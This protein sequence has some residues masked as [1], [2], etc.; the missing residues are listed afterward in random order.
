MKI[1]TISRFVF[2]I[3]VVGPTSLFAGSISGV[4]VSIDRIQDESLNTTYHFNSDIFGTVSE[5]QTITVTSPLGISYPLS[6]SEEGD[7]WGSGESG[8]EANITSQFVDGIYRFDVEY[9]DATTDSVNAQLGGVFPPFPTSL[10]LTGNTVSWD[11]WQNPILPA[12]IEFGIY[13]IGGGAELFVDLA[14]SETSFE[15]PPG[16]LQS[17]AKYELGIWFLSQNASSHKA[18]VST[19]IIDLTPTCDIQLNQLTYIDGDTVTANVFRLA[20]LT[21]DPVATELKVWLGVPGVP[22]IGVVNVGADGTFVLP[23]GTDIDLGPLPLIPV[24][25]ALPRGDYEFS[26]RMLDPTT[27]ELLTEDLNFFENQ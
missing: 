19:M 17:G 15:L 10:L 2:L 23:A 20:N 26:C 12:D 25:A 21:S 13:K 6:L 24:T 1:T 22:P 14:F 11:S 9:T 16:F 3:M 8:S 27:G 5:F 4:E 7:Q 18:S